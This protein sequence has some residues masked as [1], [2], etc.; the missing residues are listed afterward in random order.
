MKQKDD[1][2]TN[3]TITPTIINGGFVFQ[4]YYGENIPDVVDYLQNYL[5]DHRDLDL[6]IWVG[7]DSV[8]T[9]GKSA[10]YVI[11]VCI[12]RQGKGAHIIHTKLKQQIAGVYDKLW[13]ETE[14]SIKFTDYLIE[15][16]FLTIKD[17]DTYHTA[18]VLGTKVP[19][20]LDLD[21][22]T[23][24]DAVSSHLLLAGQGYCEQK[25]VQSRA[26]PLAWAASYFADHLARG[27]NLPNGN[28]ND[29]NKPK[30]TMSKKKY[31]KSK[32]KEQMTLVN[33]KV[34]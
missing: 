24:P 20:K 26:K 15:K 18:N 7:C 29:K 31:K 4:K 33:K 19:F 12:Y 9:A 32:Y 23:D 10:I 5:Y 14:L 22:N 11:A 30:E 16:K 27:K 17:G 3:R 28:N 25:N 1:V 2:K 6:Q 8:K 13:K 34:K 21:Y